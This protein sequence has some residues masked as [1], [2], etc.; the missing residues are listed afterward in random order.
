MFGRPH[1]TVALDPER[2]VEIVDTDHVTDAVF[3]LQPV[4]RQKMFGVIEDITGRFA[5]CWDGIS[6]ELVKGGTENEK[7]AVL[8]FACVMALL[9]TSDLNYSRTAP[10]L[11]LD[12]VVSFTS[13][14]VRPSTTFGWYVT[15]LALDFSMLSQNHRYKIILRVIQSTITYQEF[16]FI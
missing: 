4:S 1:Q 11:P 2:P 13:H 6:A 16:S 7:N 12:T 9:P 3:E 8:V 15:T 14:T 5:P 10:C